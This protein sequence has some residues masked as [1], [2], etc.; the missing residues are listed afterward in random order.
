MPLNFFR[1]DGLKSARRKQASA[2]DTKYADEAV[3]RLQTLVHDAAVKILKDVYGEEKYLVKGVPSDE[4]FKKAQPRQLEDQRKDEFKDLD[5]YFDLLDFKDI[6]THKSNR[7]HFKPV[8]DIA[9]EG[10]KGLAFN[11]RWLEQLNALRR[12]GAHPA[13]RQ[14]KP[15]DIT[16]LRWID[17]ELNRRTESLV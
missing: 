5:V 9:M 17:A 7:D 1:M 12:V 3:R 16:F 6:V 13:G 8:F 15:E 4:I 14:Y 2:D 10:D 11:I